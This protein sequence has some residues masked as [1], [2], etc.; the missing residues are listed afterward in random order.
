MNDDVLRFCQRKTL[1]GIGKNID[2]Y[3][4]HTKIFFPHV[5]H[6]ENSQNPLFMDTY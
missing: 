2:L 6:I 5:N 1:T 4:F 3:V